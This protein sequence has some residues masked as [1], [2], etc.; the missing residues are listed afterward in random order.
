M[1][2]VLAAAA[3]A[4]GLALSAQAHAQD[5]TSGV[6]VGTLSCHVHSG[7]G[8]IFGASHAVR[9]TFSGGGQVEHY[10]GAI[11]KFGVDIG[12]QQSGVLIWSV[13]APTE[14][15]ERGAISGHYGGVTAGATIG[16][17][18]AANALVGGSTKGIV[19]QPLSI[20]GTTGL[21]VAAGIGELSLH[22]RPSV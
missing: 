15:M 19:L 17:G 7:W 10:D 2:H 16:V 21:N 5:Q 18:I 14:R 20:E 9:C 3:L 12:Y 11:S 1:K 4:G 13:I 8:F 6:K 22:Y